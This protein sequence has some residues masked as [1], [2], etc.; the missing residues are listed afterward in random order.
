VARGPLRPARRLYRARRISTTFGRI[1]LG[2]RAHRLI[3]RRLQPPDMAE[4]WHRFHR[5]SARSV[6]DAAVELHGLIIKGCQF[7]GTRADLL[8]SEYVETLSELQDRVPPREYAVVRA[9]V[10]RELSAPVGEIFE[11]FSTTPIASASLAQVHDARLHNG[12]RVAVKVQ[13]PEIEKLVRG[14]LRNLRALFRAVDLLE[15]DFDVMP[16]IEELGTYVP[17]ELNFVNEGRNA[18]AIGRFFKHRDDVAVPRIHWE[19][20]TRRVLVMN[21]LEGIKIT[22][23]DGLRAAGLDPEQVVRILVEAYCEQILVHGFFHADPHPGNLIVQRRQDGSPR[24]VFLDFGVAKELPPLFRENAVAFAGALLTGE[25]DQMTNAMLELG[26]ETR[27]GRPAS[28]REIAAFVLELA[29]RFRRDVRLDPEFTERFGRGLPER[30][31]ENPI[32]SIPAH[33]VFLGRVLGLLSGVNRSL[34][35]R[36][37]L[38]GVIIPYVMNTARPESNRASETGKPGASNDRDSNAGSPRPGSR[39]GR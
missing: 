27:D 11:F 2:L 7:L 31:R 8:P 35:S 28:L 33:L 24:L 13:Y 29:N 26:F 9:T 34:D 21:F 16:L 18:E 23:V 39:S 36:L 4:R 20:T 38:A 3:A 17:R 37:D 12:E 6:Y 10:E 32:V 15:R 14:D 22:D 1:Y 5:A 30:I 25:V 19:F